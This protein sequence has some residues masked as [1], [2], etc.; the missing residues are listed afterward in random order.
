MDREFVVDQ[1][2]ANGGVRP[3]LLY[4]KFA[5]RFMVGQHR[6]GFAQDTDLRLRVGERA[7]RLIAS[8]EANGG[9]EGGVFQS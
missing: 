5:F 8:G 1:V 9:R 2:Q 3:S 4:T 6:L 7:V